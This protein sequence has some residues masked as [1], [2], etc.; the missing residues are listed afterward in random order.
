LSG[1]PDLSQLDP[2]K[3][4]VE[5][6]EEDYLLAL[7][8]IRRKSP[9]T[10]GATFHAQQCIE[11]YI[12]ALLASRQVLF[13]RTHDLAALGTLCRQNGIILPVS[14]NDLELLSAFAVEAHYPGTLPSQEE[15]KEALQ[16][17]RTLRRFVKKLLLFQVN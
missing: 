12:K 3:S 9:L 5:R 2:W 8:A 14:D 16:V 10:C 7:S 4:W 13:P 6:A 15:A 11:K 17:A 1:K